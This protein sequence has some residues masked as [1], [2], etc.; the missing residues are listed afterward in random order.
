M[1]TRE[2]ALRTAL[3]FV[4][5]TVSHDTEAIRVLTEGADLDELAGDLARL[6]ADFLAVLHDDPLQHLDL[7]FKALGVARTEAEILDQENTDP[8]EPE[9][10][11]LPVNGVDALALLAAR[12]NDSNEEGTPCL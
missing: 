3:A 10:R 7:M 6:V 8:G 9:T 5:A 4:R 12:K 11:R 1:N 2:D